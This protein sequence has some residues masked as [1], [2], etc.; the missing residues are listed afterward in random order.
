MIFIRSPSFEQRFKLWLKLLLPLPFQNRSGLFLYRIQRST[1]FL[2][3]HTINN[4]SY[5]L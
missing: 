1:T 4:P 2:F 5:H 3:L